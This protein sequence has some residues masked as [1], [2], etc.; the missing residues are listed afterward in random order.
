[1]MKTT[2]CLTGTTVISG[3]ADPLDDALEDLRITGSVLLHESYTSPWAIA[4]PDEARLRRILGVSADTR[5]LMFH[6]VRRG[7]FVLRV[8]GQDA[9]TVEAGEVA[10]CPT[11]AE[12]R[13]SLGRG[14]PARP[15]ESVL[16]G[17]ASQ[18]SSAATTDA[19]ELVCGVFLAHAAPLNPMLGAL[20]PVVKVATGDATFSPMLAGVAWMLAHEVD[21]QALGGFTAARVIELFCAE[22]IRA[23]QRTTGTEHAGWFR[24]LADPRIA[25]VLRRIHAAPGEPWSVEALA[26]SAALS[27]SRF[28]ARF[29]E[30]MGR[31][32]M[33][34]VAAWRANVACRLLRESKLALSEIAGRVGYESLPAFSR[35]FK[36][37]L[38]QAP[39]AWRTARLA[40]ARFAGVPRGRDPGTRPQPG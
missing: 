35:A 2:Q 20:P 38:G 19:T 7:S 34:Y 1:M 5:V 13:M 21:H 31:S 14:T 17:V 6:F 8:S 12:H 18:T 30:V 36:L 29:K 40:G 23:Y 11:G 25:E 26:A 33:N 9:V 27:P 39:A 32:V 15:I 4:V 10:I 28:A 22:S 16:R 24:G 37:Q 3:H